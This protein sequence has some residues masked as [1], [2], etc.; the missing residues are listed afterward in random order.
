MDDDAYNKAVTQ[1]M[2]D[3]AE[4]DDNAYNNAATQRRWDKADDNDTAADVDAM[5]QTMDDGCQ[6]RCR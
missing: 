1:T 3:E 6:R 2:G 4:N 5:M